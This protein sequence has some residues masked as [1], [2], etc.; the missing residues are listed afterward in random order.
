MKM[1]IGQPTWHVATGSMCAITHLLKFGCGSHTKPAVS[2]GWDKRSTVYIVTKRTRART[3][4]LR[5]EVLVPLHHR[6]VGTA[7]H[8]H[9]GASGGR[10][11]LLAR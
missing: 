4:S 2:R 8:L 10:G 7:A 11:V 9:Y 1:G 6:H 3:A 5:D